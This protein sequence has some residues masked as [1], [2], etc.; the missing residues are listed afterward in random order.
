MQQ[1]STSNNSNKQ[2]RGFQG[3]QPKQGYSENGNPKSADVSSEKES[4]SSATQPK[5]VSGNNAQA[6]SQQG[7]EKQNEKEQTDSGKQMSPVESKDSSKSQNADKESDETPMAHLDSAR[8]VFVEQIKDL[9]KRIEALTP[10]RGALS[11]ASKYVTARLTK[12]SEFFEQRTAAE[13]GSQA[14]DLVRKNYIPIALSVVGAGVGVFLVKKMGSKSEEAKSSDASE[15][16]K[17]S[18]QTKTSSPVTTNAK[19]ETHVATH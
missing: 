10:K 16:G 12:T 13:M 18:K 11:D 8:T 15:A 14:I 6:S 2:N 19:N 7:V 9:T 3:A 1:S 17:D 5:T 4:T